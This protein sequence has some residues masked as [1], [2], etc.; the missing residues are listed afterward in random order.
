[1][2]LTEKD[3]FVF[4]EEKLAVPEFNR[5]F[6]R[7]IGTEFSDKYVLPLDVINIAS[8]MRGQFDQKHINELSESIDAVGLQH[9]PIV[10]FLTA[11][12]AEEYVTES[13]MVW[14]TDL[15]LDTLTSVDGGYF[16]LSAGECRLR[17]IQLI[18][19][20]YGITQE[21]IAV[22][23][24]V[25]TCDS[26]I[27]IGRDQVAEN[28]HDTPAPERYARSLIWMYRLGQM[29]GRYKTVEDFIADSPVSRERTRDALKYFELP[30]CV[31]EAVEEEKIIRYGHAVALHQ[32]IAPYFKWLETES[33]IQEE[34][35]EEL[36]YDNFNS[37]VGLIYAKG[38]TVEETRRIV[39]SWV[40]DMENMQQSFEQLFTTPIDA[41]H[42]EREK[43]KS[44]RR[45][46][47]NE[48]SA[49]LTN[50]AGAIDRS[51][52][53]DGRLIEGLE[54]NMIRSL[55]AISKAVD[56][57]RR[58]STSEKIGFESTRVSA[59]VVELIDIQPAQEG[60]GF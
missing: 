51:I 23:C 31:H 7:I 47:L 22:V 20:K 15:S 55:Q 4:D 3:S 14:G 21:G 54:P 28:I 38:W 17:A 59:E 10:Y 58:A 52:R 29:E 39:A 56:A 27:E 36:F 24:E 9:N 16:V 34:Y 37:K 48:A 19:N 18:A 33:K 41:L 42:L 53:Q 13:N 5:H 2:T 8:Q 43:I 57:L 44:E 60:L 50:L 6:E 45:Q 30:S 40:D 11:E 49:K 12:Q 1:M 32:Y 35:W 46:S 26:I 25:K